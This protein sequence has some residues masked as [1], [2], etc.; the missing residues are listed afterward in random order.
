MDGTFE[1]YKGGAPATVPVTILAKTV[2]CMAAKL[3]GVAGLGG[4]NAVNLQNWLLHFGVESEAF[5]EEMA[6]WM[7]LW[8]TNESPPWPAYCTL[9]PRRLIALDKQPRV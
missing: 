8:L 3:L 2:K 7:M 6:S 4:T 5:C 1:H 9:M